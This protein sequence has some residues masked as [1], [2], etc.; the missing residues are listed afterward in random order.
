[1]LRSSTRFLV[2]TS[3]LLTACA[4]ATDPTAEPTATVEAS[5]VASPSSSP[6]PSLAPTA[7]P[8]VAPSASL[9]APS[10]D[11]FAV[12]PDPAADALFLERDECENLQDGYQLQFPDDWYTNT[13]IRDVPACSWFAPEFYTVDDFD[14]IPDE[15]AIDISWLGGDRG[16]HGEILTS[17]D[18]TAGGQSASRVEVAGTPD[19]PTSGTSYEYVVQLGPTREEGPNL[20]ARTDTT[21]GGDHELNKAVLDRMMATIEFVGSVQLP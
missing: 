14:E 10:G 15:I 2:V 19:E 8:S 6:E 3:L 17:Q 9:A 18:G 21:M 11:G 7:S 1:M 20:V 16:Y 12:T 5:A 4:G 13:E